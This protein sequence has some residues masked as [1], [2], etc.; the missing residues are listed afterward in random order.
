[1]SQ[2]RQRWKKRRGGEDGEEI[3]GSRGGGDN[4]GRRWGR[5]KEHTSE[6]QKGRGKR[7]GKTRV[8]EQHRATDVRR[9]INEISKFSGHCVGMGSWR[10]TAEPQNQPES[11]T[12]HKQP[13]NNVL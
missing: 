2:M 10:H 12:K 7:E 11:W 3:K 1:M 6:R 13:V 5:R 8:S 4:S 9:I